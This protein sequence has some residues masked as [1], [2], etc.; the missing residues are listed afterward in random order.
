VRYR[1][2]DAL[3]AIPRLTVAQLDGNQCPGGSQIGRLTLDT[4]AGR[5]VQPVY[6][7]VPPHGIA[8]QFGMQVLGRSR[9]P[10]VDYVLYCPI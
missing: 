1:L 7:M 3:A 8:A 9:L 5:F 4:S 10:L 6:N 2:F